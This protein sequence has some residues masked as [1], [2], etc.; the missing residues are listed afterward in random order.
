MQKEELAK[1]YAEGIM[2]IYG[3]YIVGYMKEQREE[4]KKMFM[5]DLVKLALGQEI[6]QENY[7][8]YREKRGGMCYAAGYENDFMLLVHLAK[9]IKEKLEIMEKPLDQQVMELIMLETIN[10]NEIEMLKARQRYLERGTR[11]L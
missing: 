1:K 6:S 11:C 4:Y 8:T 5:E 7:K 2:E 3:R 9:E 10:K